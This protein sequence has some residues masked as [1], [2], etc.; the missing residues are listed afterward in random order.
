MAITKLDDDWDNNKYNE[1]IDANSDDTSMVFL[2]KLVEKVD[3]SIDLA[4]T[5][6]TDMAANNA[7]TSF[8]G[9][10]TTNKTALVGNTTTISTSQANTITANEKAVASNNSAIKTNTTNIATNTTNI[11]GKLS[12]TLPD[13]NTNLG[14]MVEV[15]K[16]GD[17]T[18]VFLLSIKDE[19]SGKTIRKTATLNFK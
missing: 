5:H 1:V 19:R 11:D 18:L 2:K 3:E 12:K 16:N 8:P 7:K 14:C 4:N 6:I 9:F 17:H 13:K 15:D 10:G